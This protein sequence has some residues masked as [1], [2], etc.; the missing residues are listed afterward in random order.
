V[1]HSY[2][3]MGQGQSIKL[4]SEYFPL[5]DPYL[6]KGIRIQPYLKVFVDQ[7]VLPPPKPVEEEDMRVADI[8]IQFEGKRCASD[9]TRESVE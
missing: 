7:G 6:L 1:I 2:I 4:I 9:F 3:N 8:M 5:H